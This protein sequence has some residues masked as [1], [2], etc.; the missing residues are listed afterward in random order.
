M[1]NKASK[2]TEPFDWHFW[3][4]HIDKGNV[5]CSKTDPYDAVEHLNKLG[6]KNISKLVI[7]HLNINLLSNKFDQLKLITKKNLTF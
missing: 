3:I 4:K 1:W 2:N 5:N 6:L 7:C